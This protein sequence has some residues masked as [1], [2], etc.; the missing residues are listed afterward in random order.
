MDATTVVLEVATGA[1]GLALAVTRLVTETVDW[2]SG[3]RRS[4]A[5]GEATT[6]SG[7]VGDAGGVRSGAGRTGAWE[8][9]G[10]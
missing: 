8:D 1:V 6:R 2:W 5:V 4:A 9:D 7:V 10:A 3:R